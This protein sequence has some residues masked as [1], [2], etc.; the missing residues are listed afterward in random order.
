LER[1]IL[2]LPELE[3]E[4]ELN[5]PELELELELNLPELELELE[6]NLPELE[7]VGVDKNCN[8][9]LRVSAFKILY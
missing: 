8:L 2:N 3:L 5:L 6:L 1:F 7:L 4:L 9:G